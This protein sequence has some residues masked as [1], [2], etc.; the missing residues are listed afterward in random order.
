MLA[1]HPCCGPSRS[2]GVTD[3][4]HL[5]SHKTRAWALWRDREDTRGKQQIEAGQ[6]HGRKIYLKVSLLHLLGE[7]FLL[8]NHGRCGVSLRSFP[9]A[10]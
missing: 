6:V 5:R 3:H 1:P 10:S 7:A 4:L 8:A 9:E 2:L